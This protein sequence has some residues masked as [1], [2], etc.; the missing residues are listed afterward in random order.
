MQGANGASARRSGSF[1]RNA[2]GS[3]S[4]QSSASATLANG[5]TGS[6]SGS[7]SRSAD[8]TVNGSRSSSATLANGNSYNGSTTVQNGAVTHAGTCTDASGAVIA[9]P[10]R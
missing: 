5:A 10:G 6:T 1:S 7:L 4:Q 8:G 2:D 9:C 3:A